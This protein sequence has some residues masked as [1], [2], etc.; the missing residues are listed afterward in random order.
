MFLL[1]HGFNL[2][3]YTQLASDYELHLLKISDNDEE[4]KNDYINRS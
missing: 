4:E 1:Q 2:L 3:T